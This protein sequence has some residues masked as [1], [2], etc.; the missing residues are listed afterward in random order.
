MPIFLKPT[1][2]VNKLVLQPT[3]F[4][5]RHKNE[6]FAKDARAG[7]NPTK[8]SRQEVL[9]KKSPIS[10]YALGAIMFVVVGGGAYNSVIVFKTR[11]G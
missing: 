2:L 6:K 3:A 9:S 7:K 10:V 8:P 4:E 1:M 11:R 5:M